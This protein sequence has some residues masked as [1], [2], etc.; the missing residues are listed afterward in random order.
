VLFQYSRSR[1][2]II[3]DAVCLSSGNNSTQSPITA[4]AGVDGGNG[5]VVAPHFR[6]RLGPVHVR[7]HGSLSS[8]CPFAGE[9]A[10]C[11]TI[12][13]IFG[14]RNRAID[15]HHFPAEVFWTL[16]RHFGWEARYQGARRE[17]GRRIRSSPYRDRPLPGLDRPP[18]L[19]A[20]ASNGPFLLAVRLSE[21]LVG[22]GHAP[23]ARSHP[24]AGRRN[25]PRC[26]LIFGCSGFPF[27]RWI[28]SMF[29]LLLIKPYGPESSK[30]AL[31][32]CLRSLVTYGA[33][34][35]QHGCTAIWKN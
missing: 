1:S 4:A 32:R 15:K 23:P 3:C 2:R 12:R 24:P 28:S 14:A 33:P 13:P 19:H 30:G 7:D 31:R 16:A 26:E 25:N 29:M 21:P 20:F 5:V 34:S 10:Q 27:R 11:G 17:S 35:Q 22:R 8:P 6:G 18:A 9:S